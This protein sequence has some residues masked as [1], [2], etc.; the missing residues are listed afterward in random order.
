MAFDKRTGER[1]WVSEYR[2]PAG[3]TTGL[4]P[5]TVEGIPCL[6]VLTFNKLLVLRLDPGHE[7]GTVVTYPW[8][9]AWANNDLTPAVEGNSALIG[10]GHTHKSICK[11]QITFGGAKRLWEQPYCSLVGSSACNHD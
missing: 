7:G 8:K 5:M 2:G 6:A 11:L 9:T 10:A 3:H 1:R 4:V